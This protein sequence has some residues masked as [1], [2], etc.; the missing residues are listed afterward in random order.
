MNKKKF[1]YS[2]VSVTAN[3][4]ETIQI[5]ESVQNNMEE[6][7]HGDRNSSEEEGPPVSF[8]G[9]KIPAL[10]P[11][12]LKSFVFRYLQCKRKGKME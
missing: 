6:N 11:W 1:F 12:I 4:E 2:R 9:K 7:E 10:F 3:C 8:E 5:K